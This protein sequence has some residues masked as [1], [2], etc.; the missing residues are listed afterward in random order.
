MADRYCVS[1]FATDRLEGTTAVVFCLN[2][3]LSKEQ[4]QEIALEENVPATCFV[5]QINNDV[6]NIHFFNSTHEIQLCG[7]GLLASAWVLAEKGFKVFQFRTIHTQVMAKV[8]GD[9]SVWLEFHELKAEPAKIPSWADDCLS[10]QPLT[11]YKAG[12]SD[13]YWIMEW[14]E[15]FQLSK[16]QV[17]GGALK[18][19][20]NRALIATQ[21]S[22]N[23]DYDYCFRYFAPQHGVTEDKATGSA[24]RV[25]ISYWYHKLGQSK[26]TARQLSKEGAELN[27]KFVHGAVWISGNV[28][29]RR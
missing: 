6:F 26:V 21:K 18:R 13:G 12:A 15:D 4:M 29:I 9:G 1:V 27:G 11:A 7:H 16:L 22:T 2:E 20:T 10:S 14:P 23:R 19:S 3:S 24:H 25:L 17:D 28:T 8:E 5:Q